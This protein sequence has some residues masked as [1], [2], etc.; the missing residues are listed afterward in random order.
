MPT[1]DLSTEEIALL[2]SAL[3]S[4]EYWEYREDL[5]HGSGFIYDPE[6]GSVEEQSEAWS[7]VQRGRALD[8]RLAQLETST[9]RGSRFQRSAKATEGDP[10]EYAG[11]DPHST[12]EADGVRDAG[13]A[14]VWITTCRRCGIELR[15]S[16]PDEDGNVVWEAV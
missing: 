16:E 13:A 14:H 8:A 11:H 3:D 7:E 5:P 15:E 2:R 4:R 6:P 12:D 10:C 9:W 1:I